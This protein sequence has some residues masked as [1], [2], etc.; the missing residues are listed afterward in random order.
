MIAE[1]QPRRASNFLIGLLFLLASVAC[2]KQGGV[3]DQWF[4]S[5]ALH[6][7]AGFMFACSWLPFAASVKPSGMHRMHRD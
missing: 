7:C 2:W 4:W 1:H 5:L 3:A 6:A